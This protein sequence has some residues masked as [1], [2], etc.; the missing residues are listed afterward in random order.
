MPKSKRDKVVS[1]TQVKKKGSDRKNQLID[2][3]CESFDGRYAHVFVFSVQN[4]RNK[5]LKDLRMAWQGSSRFFYGKLKL[6]HLGIERSG[7]EN[8]DGLLQCIKGDAGLLFTNKDTDEIQKHFTEALDMDFLRQGA[9]A[10]STFTIP[11]GPLPDF[12]F[13]MEPKLRALGVPTKLVDGIIQCESDFTVCTEG[14]VLSAD[15]CKILKHF[16][17]RMA[18][19]KI[20]LRCRYTIVT[21]E[22]K[23]LTA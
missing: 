1:L 5:T 22:F 13:D 19:F 14:D 23:A 21:E 18:P 8:V 11:A 17:K 3:I 2:D 4:M 16:E 10:V 15:D 12:Q 20:N 9:K 7:K 6:M